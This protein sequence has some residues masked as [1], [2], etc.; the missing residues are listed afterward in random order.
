MNG[1]YEA[2]V[3]KVSAFVDATSERR[4]NDLHC[5]K[6]CDACC[7]A[8]LTVTEVEAA[9]VR[10]GLS[11][12]STEQRQHVRARGQRELT[13]EQLSH[14]APR[15]AMLED[16][17]SCAIY[18]HRPLVCRTQGHALRYPPNVVPLAAVRAHAKAGEVTWC[19]LNYTNAAPQSADVLDA[20]LVDQLLG[21]VNLRFVQDDKQR[22]LLR[23]ALSAL[24]AAE[25]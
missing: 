23:E 22:A 14:E 19:P 3:S 4:A 6:G 12:L 9:N 25:G 8:W 20:Q 10:A 7:H 2:L 11:A 24:A 1:E 21:V 17:G 13:R 15:C 5:R 16:D 18:A